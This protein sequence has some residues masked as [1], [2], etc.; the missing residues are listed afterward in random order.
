MT[1]P[2]KYAKRTNIDCLSLVKEIED[3]PLIWDVKNASH[4]NR[5]A[6]NE[7]W[8]E[9]GNALNQPGNYCH[10]VVL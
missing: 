4:H 1:R 6:L 7:S 3:R 9:I 8:N 5:V 2:R 10:C